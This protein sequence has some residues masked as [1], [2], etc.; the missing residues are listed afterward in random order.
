VKKSVFSF[1]MLVA[2]TAFAESDQKNE[3]GL[4]LG[5]EFVPQ[6]TTTVGDKVDFGNSV[7]FS[8]DYARRLAGGNTAVFLELPFAA[9]PSHNVR[10]LS[11]GSI[12]SLA[13]LYV[14]PSLRVNF[15]HHA[16]FSAWLSGGFGYG[17][18]EGSAKLKSGT[19]NSDRYTNTG[20]AQFGGGV[21]FRTGLKVLFPITLRGEVRD[22][23]TVTS[24]H[25]GIPVQNSGQHNV[26]V[27]GG[28]VL[29]F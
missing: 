15:F 13:T 29:H 17:L 12:T 7:V 14:T 11:P 8:S 24:P 18:Y 22:Y 6:R 23:Y 16:R 25:F 4:L 3:L 5:G 10:T 1:L 28:F 9:A 26:V 27:T 20:T 2:M 21:D 19:K